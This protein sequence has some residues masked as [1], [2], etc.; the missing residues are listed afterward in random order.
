MKIY[1]DNCSFN[2]PFDDQTYL[3]IYLESQAKLQIQADIKSEKYEL[4]WSYIMDYEVGKKPFSDR[5]EAIMEWKHIASETVTEETSEILDL[6]EALTNDGIK[7]Y[8]ALHIA[9]AKAA[10]CEYFITTDKRLL[11]AQLP[12]MA[13]VNPIQFVIAMEESI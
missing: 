11:R 2:R 12:G 10:G 13:V 5:R 6:A 8:D 4:V 7:T 1:L 9:C 3:K